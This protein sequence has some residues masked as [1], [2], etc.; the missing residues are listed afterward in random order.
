LTQKANASKAR[1][2][3]VFTHGRKPGPLVV[4]AIFTNS[5]LE[6]GSKKKMLDS[7][8]ARLIEKVLHDN[9]L[10]WKARGIL[11]YIL[12]IPTYWEISKQELSEKSPNGIK[13]F[14]TGWAEL[15]KLGYLE[16]RRSTDEKGHPIWETILYLEKLQD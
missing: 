6:K 1:R 9:R 14:Q 7:K 12:T 10:S 5:K 16:R 15:E 2:Q 3:S 13:S 4:F 8:R 11:A